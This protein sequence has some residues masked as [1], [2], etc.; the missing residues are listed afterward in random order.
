[1]THPPAPPP[2]PPPLPPVPPPVPPVPPPVPL[3]PPPV[4]PAP[5][6][7]RPPAGRRDR[8]YDDEVRGACRYERGLA[9]KALIALAII[10]ALI[11]AR[12]LWF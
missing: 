12:I 10:A 7:V 2:V 1:M 6:P 4:P 9:V 5:P 3:A 8:P 11:A